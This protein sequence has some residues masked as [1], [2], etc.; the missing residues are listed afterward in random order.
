M[1]GRQKYKQA[2]QNWHQ[3][4]GTNEFIRAVNADIMDIDLTLNAVDG[5]DSLMSKTFLMNSL[6]QIFA[7]IG[8]I[9]E[10]FSE[11]KDQ[12]DFSEIVRMMINATGNDTEAITLS[13]E[14]RQMKAQKDQQAQMQAMQMQ[15]A[16]EQQAIQLQAQ[17]EQAKQQARLEV[18]AQLEQ[19][20]AQLEA[21]KTEAK[22][23]ARAQAQVLIQ[24]SKAALDLERS[25]TEIDLKNDAKLEE[26][27]T[28][29]REQ[30][31]ADLARMR[32]EAKLE[33]ENLG[34]SVGHQGNNIKEKR[35]SNEPNKG[36]SKD[37]SKKE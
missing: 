2:I 18:E 11:L 25:E 20:K 37:S 23:Q 5:A 28:H 7:S 1:V 12:L 26:I 30:L 29:V 22:E 33:S 31:V 8:Q 32:E 17:L 3:V 14:E 21:V 13:Q 4:P 19:I 9:P 16:Q 35:V 6:Q 27:V 15:Q 34:I 24:E 10:L 36:A